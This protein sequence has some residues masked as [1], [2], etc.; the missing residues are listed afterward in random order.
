MAIFTRIL[1]WTKEETEVFLALVRKDMKDAKIHSYWEM[2][3]TSP[4]K[5]LIL[6]NVQIQRHWTKAMNCGGV[7]LNFFKRM[8]FLF[9]HSPLMYFNAMKPLP[10]L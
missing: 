4:I 3:V 10:Y 8:V 6:I 2:C 9:R 7:R 5:R 1:G